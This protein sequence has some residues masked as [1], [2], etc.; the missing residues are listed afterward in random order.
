MSEKRFH[1]ASQIFPMMDPGEIANLADDIKNNGLREPIVLDSQKGLIVDGRNRFL[2]CRIAGVKPQY[3]VWDGRGS[4]LSYVVS[5]NL[6]RRHLDASQRAMVAAKL[7]TLCD[8]QRQLGKFA[9]VATQA[10]ASEMLNVGERTIRHARE[11]TAHGVP[12]LV[13]AVE[14]GRVSVSAAADLAD[15][16]EEEQRRVLELS[17]DEV[18]ARAKE[19]RAS[20]AQDNGRGDEWR[21]PPDYIDRAR[22]VMGSID[23]DPASTARAN[24]IVKAKAFF[25]KGIDGRTREWRGNVWLNPP[26]STPLIGEFVSM[27]VDATEDKKVPQATLLTNNATETGWFQQALRAADFC[28]FPD[29]RIAFIGADGRP[30]PGNRQA[31]AFFFFGCDLALVQREFGPVGTLVTTI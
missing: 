29:Q 25:D 19:I 20:H 30:A 26:F 5:L 18:L 17:D 28:C 21:T 9:E 1:A 3:V 2:A 8:G 31:Q 16:S 4:L 23:L 14:R 22:R 27:L 24:E 15:D 13:A 7:A 12:E 6:H 11:V 10:E